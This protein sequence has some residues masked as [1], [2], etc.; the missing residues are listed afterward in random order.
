MKKIIGF[1]LLCSMSLFSAEMKNEENIDYTKIANQE[2]LESVNHWLDG[3]FGLKPHKTNYILPLGHS[4]RVYK[5]YEQGVVYKDIEAELQVSLK[6]PI[7]SNL[8]GLGE[9]YYLAYTHKA[10]WQIYTESSPFRETNYSPEA[11]VSFPISDHYS[12][13]QLRN[14]KLGL[15]HTSNGKSQTWNQSLY[16]YHYLDPNNESR[17]VNYTYVEATLQHHSF[18][19]DF[20]IWYRIPE[21][22]EKDDNPDYVDYVGHTELKINYFYNQHMFCLDARYNI[23]TGNGSVTG[24]YSYPIG[25][26]VYIYAKAFS[27]YGESLIDY[28]QY[29][30]KFSI[31]F[32]F[33][34]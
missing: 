3:D 8:L 22:I 1:V 14:I 16:P 23:S 7:G 29:I 4:N 31:G 21:T 17:S 11:F 26:D 19:T 20:R 27:G 5:S 6:L 10:F 33:S 9:K 12:M 25:D 24:S 13:F 34:R 18:I 32:S 15:A 30:T 28:N 2:T